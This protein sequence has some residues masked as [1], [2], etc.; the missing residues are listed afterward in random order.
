VSNASRL[1]GAEADSFTWH[2]G[3]CRRKLRYP[4]RVTAKRFARMLKREHGNRQR[5]YRCAVCDRWHLRT[6]GK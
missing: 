2:A 1:N 3:V 6:I 5:P 4:D